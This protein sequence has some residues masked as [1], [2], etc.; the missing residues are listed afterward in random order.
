MNGTIELNDIILHAYHGVFEQERQI[1][2]TY[3]VCL[4]LTADYSKACASDALADTINYA[5]VTAAIT[6]EMDIP[7]R[8]IE[9]VAARI[10]Q[11][12]LNDFPM[13]QTVEVRL[14]KQH[15]PIPGTEIA[16]ACFCQCFSRTD[17]PHKPS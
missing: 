3:R 4:R 17:S 9:H 13:L 14:C 8:L 6:K 7:S 11:R 15:P 12:L 2:G 10:G 5:A 16:E 1:G